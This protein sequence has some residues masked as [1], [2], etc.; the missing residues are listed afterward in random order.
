MDLGPPAPGDKTEDGTDLA[1]V[2]TL[3][4]VLGKLGLKMES[5]KAKSKV[6]VIDHIEKP[7]EN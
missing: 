6:Y 7:T 5:T 1:N 3:F 4:M 2:P